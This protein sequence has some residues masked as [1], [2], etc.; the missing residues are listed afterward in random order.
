MFLYLAVLVR[1]KLSFRNTQG[2]QPLE[3]L[4][5]SCTAHT[6]VA[7]GGDYIVTVESM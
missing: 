5:D 3:R 7:E 2:I 6:L 1:S 4:S